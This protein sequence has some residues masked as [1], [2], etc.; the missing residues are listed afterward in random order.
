MPKF[1]KSNTITSTDRHGIETD[2]QVLFSADEI[3][4]RALLNPSLLIEITESHAVQVIRPQGKYQEVSEDVLALL[5]EA[6]E[7][8]TAAL[9]A[10][11]DKKPNKPAP[12]VTPDEE[13][14]KAGD[15]ADKPADLSFGG[16]TGSGSSKA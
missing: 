9:E 12:E 7:S 11:V 1:I 15:A 2:R 10:K 14:P 13:P 4:S 5:E 6:R 3:V 8:A 16:K